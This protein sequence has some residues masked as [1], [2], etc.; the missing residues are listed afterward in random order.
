MRKRPEDIGLLPDGDAA[1]TA[2]SAKPVLYIVDPVW[3]GTDWTLR[4]AIRTARFW[5]IPLPPMPP[6]MFAWYSVQVHQTR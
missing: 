3:A 6:A 5:W 4:R 2:N 1:P